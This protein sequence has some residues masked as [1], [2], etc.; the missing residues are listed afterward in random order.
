MRPVTQTETSDPHSGVRA[1]GAA[2]PER[3]LPLRQVIV[4]RFRRLGF[5]NKL[6][7][8]STGVALICLLLAG[9]IL[10]TSEV[11][12]FRQQMLARAV[13]LADVTAANVEASL[14][15]DDGHS[16]TQ[17][18]ANLEPEPGVQSA[19]VLVAREVGIEVFAAFEREGAAAAA[20]P[21]VMQ[22]GHRFLADRLEV[23]RPVL[24]EGS[25]IGFVH[26][27]VGL[28]QLD[29]TVRRFVLTLGGLGMLTVLVA[30]ALSNR[31]QRI[32]T[33]PVDELADTARAISR[34]RDYS[35]RAR[36]L[37]EDEL[38]ALT[39]A[40]N[41]MLDE[42]QAHDAARERVELQ[43]R[44]LNESLEAKVSER[45]RELEL[46][47]DELRQ[48]ID[49]VRAA[50]SQL[51]EAEK[52]AALGGLVA[53]V[54]HEINTPLGMCVTMVS[55]LGEQVKTLHRCYES[56]IRRTDLESFMDSCDQSVA[57]IESNLNRAAE[58]VRS[59]KLVAVDQSS[60]AR[61]RFRVADY[62]GEVL[63]SL[64]PKLKK[65]T[66]QVELDCDPAIEIESYPGVVA[67]IIT[68]LTVNALIH[69]FG[70][71]GAAGTISIQGRRDGDRFELL[72]A[73]DGAGMSEDIR[74][75][76][77]DPFFTTRRGEGGSGLGLHIVYNQVTQT[78]GGTIDC[79]SA[80][81]QGSRFTIRFP[82]RAAT[83][84]P[85]G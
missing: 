6:V 29:A 11:R 5:R 52:M 75:H 35:V 43:I 64:R 62:L 84:E 24:Q 8:L 20:L 76:V 56:G 79:Y 73:D 10:I 26:L 48:A 7:V 37:A 77:F 57:I 25:P 49:S 51:V 71:H 61:R 41:A 55:H 46:R 50:Q 31:L 74:Q 44:Q 59:F 85:A 17:L 69:A 63:L 18:L 80:P 1:A 65:T 33:R 58:L 53:G 42:V 66:V 38:G 83:V 15:F 21:E 2:L 12:Q 19:R 36:V 16:A 45:T 82:A 68:N 13:A 4:R 81:G 32:I 39:C 27:S 3:A 14:S 34:D 47:N 40:F 70:A 78:L 28:G 22:P 54:A 67:Q 23:L 30:W 60:E 9:A 72:F